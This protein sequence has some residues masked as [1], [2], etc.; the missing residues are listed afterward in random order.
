MEAAATGWHV[1]RRWWRGVARL[2]RWGTGGALACAGEVG[3]V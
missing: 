3:V 2:E 1:A